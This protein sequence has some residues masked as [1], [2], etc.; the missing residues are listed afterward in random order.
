MK[1][2]GCK[3][4]YI[5]PNIHH[6]ELVVT[7]VN[8]LLRRLYSKFYTLERKVEYLENNCCSG[9]QKPDIPDDSNTDEEF[10]FNVTPNTEYEDG[11]IMVSADAQELVFKL[12]AN[13][14][15]TWKVV[16]NNLLTISPS[17]GEYKVNS[18]TQ[19]V[20]VSIP[21][22]DYHIDDTYTIRFYGTNGDDTIVKTFQIVQNAK[23][24]QES[25]DITPSV[26]VFEDGSSKDSVLITMS[27]E[28][29]TAKIK[30]GSNYSDYYYSEIE[31][32][33]TNSDGTTW[34]R[35]KYYSDKDNIT[36]SDIKVVITYTAGSVSK[37]LTLI[38]KDISDE[39]GEDT[40]EILDLDPES[41]IFTE[42]EAAYVTVTHKGDF[43]YTYNGTDFA[44][45]TESVTNN[46]DG[47]VSTVLKVSPILYDT[48]DNYG[49]TAVI[50]FE[51]DGTIKYLT[52]T[53]NIS[54]V[55]T[56]TDPDNGDNSDTGDS[57]D[58]G[59][60]ED[61]TGGDN[62]NGD[63]NSSST[64]TPTNM[65]IKVAASEL[66]FDYTKGSQNTVDVT[67][68]HP[69][70][71]RHLN[72][73]TK[74]FNYYEEDVTTNSDGS[75]TRRYTITTM[76]EN[77]TGKNITD[78]FGFD[79]WYYPYINACT[80]LIQKPKTT[81][82]TPSTST[83]TKYSYFKSNDTVA[84]SAINLT[85]SSIKQWTKVTNSLTSN[86]YTS[87][88][89]E[90]T[91]YE[92]EGNYFFGVAIPSSWSIK[93]INNTSKQDE[94]DIMSTATINITDPHDDGSSDVVEYTVYYFEGQ[95]T[96]RGDETFT[97]KITN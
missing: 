45:V 46:P 53:N 34:V 97:I 44:F 80:E 5:E 43:K 8:A 79:Y 85:E 9:N 56:P 12:T 37:D 61:N 36:G 70:L 7:D 20:T 81:T 17:T 52:L 54:K 95:P 66:E 39:D 68:S 24:L 76:S 28:N 38:F 88:N 96:I 65:W 75:I 55:E 82:D 22:N 23:E 91:V 4:P 47:T 30:E 49:V 69:D 48:I 6:G 2:C 72:I 29:Y 84:A 19:E 63:D 14:D 58:N 3:P 60:T 33:G 87:I 57:G 77:T 50:P 74:K 21:A 78:T 83:T 93:F 64:T 32:T 27:S 35:V 59:D 11:I 86:D 41:I 40:T 89:I 10:E 67:Y 94:I 18:K 1:M 15:C 51:V 26:I 25:I 16:A 92:T 13:K 73:D 62:N 71:K 31:E 90:D 42:D